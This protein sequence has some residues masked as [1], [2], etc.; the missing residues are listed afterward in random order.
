MLGT[1]PPRKP[2]TGQQPRTTGRA[3][4]KYVGIP[5]DLYDQVKAFADADERTVPAILKRALREYLARHKPGE[6]QQS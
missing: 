4:F 1:M 2:D 3:N 6:C 5:L